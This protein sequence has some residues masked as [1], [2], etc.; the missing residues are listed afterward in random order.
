[1][2]RQRRIEITAIRRR[3]T[4]FFNEQG[5]TPSGLRRA[6]PNEG[7][8]PRWFVFVVTC[9]KTGFERVRGNSSKERKPN[10]E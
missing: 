3:T 5:L 8:W 2:R 9:F 10:H 4:I 7:V 6:P 1:M